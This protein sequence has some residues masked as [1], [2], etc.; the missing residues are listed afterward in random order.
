MEG[1]A[2]ISYALVLR[3]CF[4]TRGSQA[5]FCLLAQNVLGRKDEF[6]LFAAFF[7]ATMMD[8]SLSSK[9][10]NFEV[11][12][13]VYSPGPHVQK[14]WEQCESPSDSQVSSSYCPVKSAQE[15]RKDEE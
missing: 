2:A 9:P 6:L 10:V 3:Q 12:I 13:G 1:L 5:D 11:S 4:G 7:E 14:I 8:S 15:V